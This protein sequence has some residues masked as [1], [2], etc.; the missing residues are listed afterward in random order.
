MNRQT[1]NENTHPDNVAI[2]QFSTFHFDFCT[3]NQ[4]RPA[5][6]PSSVFCGALHLSRTLYICRENSTNQP[7]F[8]QN[9]PNFHRGKNEPNPIYKKG[10]RRF[11]TPSDNEKRTQ[12]EPNSN[13]I[14][15]W[16]NP[17]QPSV[18]QRFT[19]TNHPWPLKKTNP[20]R[21]QSNPIPTSPK[22]PTPPNY[23]QP[24]L[25][26]S[27]VHFLLLHIKRNLQTAGNRI[28]TLLTHSPMVRLLGLPHR[29]P[30]ESAKM[31]QK[32]SHPTISKLHKRIP[33]H[34]KYKQLCA[35]AQVVCPI[36]THFA[37][38]NFSRAQV[39]ARRLRDIM[40]RSHNERNLRWL[41]SSE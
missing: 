30:V 27:A 24:K 17:M 4:S 41:K 37:H 23:P 12:N 18:S 21:T 14:F 13:P 28:H 5:G 26:V 2:P 29:A 10:L 19:T 20:K 11:Y 6:N 34:L 8:M 9:E 32:E 33:N 36:G 38:P 35:S 3:L 15:L 40:R 31:A 7:L 39:Q 1:N 16:T 25:D 22:A